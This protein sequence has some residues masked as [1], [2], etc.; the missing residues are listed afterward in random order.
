MVIIAIVTLSM[1]MKAISPIMDKVCEDVAITK[2]T[3]VANEKTTEVMSN[4]TYEDLINVYKDN[5]GNVTMMQS[6]IVTIND[7]TSSIA[8]KIQ[9]ALNNDDESIA[10][11]KL[12]KLYRN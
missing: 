6:N 12:R 2:A 8:E 10:S 1:S 9:N 11:V 4:Y 5:S 3:V 7:I